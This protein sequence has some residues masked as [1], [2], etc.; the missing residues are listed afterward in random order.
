MIDRLPESDAVP[1]NDAARPIDLAHLDRA[2][3]GDRA[4]RREVLTLFD[5][6]AARLATE[7]AA[8]GDA[9]VRAEAAHGLRGAALGVGANAVAAATAAI[10][11]A[12]DD[13]VE[14][15]GLLARLAARIAEVR[16]AIGDLLAKD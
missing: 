3:F 11:G 4:L 9:R 2:T 15:P 1:A 6:Q 12:I 8:A 7:I 10:E 14:L 5:R 13:P 16:H